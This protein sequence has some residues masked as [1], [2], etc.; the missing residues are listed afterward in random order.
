M[1]TL[2]AQALQRALGDNYLT[3]APTQQ[4]KSKLFLE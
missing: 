1:P 2:N 3:A 4:A